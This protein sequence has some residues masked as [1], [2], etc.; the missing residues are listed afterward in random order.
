MWLFLLTSALVAIALLPAC[1]NTQPDNGYPPAKTPAIDSGED[2]AFVPANKPTPAAQ[3]TGAQEQLILIKNGE[4]Y[5]AVNMNGE[6]VYNIEYSSIS[7][8][9]A[10][11]CYM[12]C[13][14]AGDE[15]YAVGD[16]DGNIITGYDFT[17]FRRNTDGSILYLLN[18]TWEGN[19]NSYFSVFDTSTKSFLLTQEALPKSLDYYDFTAVDDTFL[20]RMESASGSQNLGLY[21]LNDYLSG[22]KEPI[23]V[24]EADYAQ[25]ISNK[26]YYIL[27]REGSGQN[28]DGDSV[29]GT[30]GNIIIPYG[31]YE[32]IVPN[33][34]GAY[35]A[36]TNNGIVYLNENLELERTIPYGS[37]NAFLGDYG[38]ALGTD[39]K[40][41]V[42]DKNGGPVNSNYYDEMRRHHSFWLFLQNDGG[43]A[44]VICPDESPRELSL[45]TISAPGDDLS[46]NE[47]I[48][49]FDMGNL[50]EIGAVNKFGGSLSLL[51]SPYDFSRITE[52]GKYDGFLRHY[53]NIYGDPQRE[54]AMLIMCYR[55]AYKNSSSTIYDIFTED[56]HMILEGVKEIIS[57]TQ[58]AIAYTK[59]FKMIVSTW[60][61][62]LIYSAPIFG[63][64]E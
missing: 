57:V 5:G 53:Y 11:D 48:W 32:Y 38:Y 18:I 58:N 29:I 16:K 46:I 47:K 61:G 51:I 6:L 3:N 54:Y 37:C 55:N 45:D 30:K 41:Q 43:S 4:K 1:T 9:G 25:G 22:S 7:R 59:G 15:L 52:P 31:V 56:G 49:V 28:P 64:L 17:G 12:L 13:E 40:F 19:G 14:S 44:I 34:G 21:N 23:G 50:I 24:F 26:P 36:K 62:E 8:I 60:D 20:M 33:D 10:S 63:N 35:T 42:I 27:T 2:N 39:G